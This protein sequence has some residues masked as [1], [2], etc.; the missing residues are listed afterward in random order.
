M[1]IKN[2][3]FCFVEIDPLMAY[4]NHEGSILC[5]ECFSAGRTLSRHEIKSANMM[6][7]QQE[8]PDNSHYTRGSIEPWAYI[9]ANNLN[10]FEGSAVKYITRWRHKNGVE[11]LRKARVYIDELIRQEEAK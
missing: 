4:K 6:P 7:V 2:C 3:Q 10:F 5:R 11:D 1:T 8:R 9:Q